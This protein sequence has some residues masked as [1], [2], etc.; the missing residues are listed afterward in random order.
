MHWR[1]GQLNIMDYRDI[2]DYSFERILKLVVSNHMMKM[3][4][5]AQNKHARFI[6]QKAAWHAQV[7]N[8]WFMEYSFRVLETFLMRQRNLEIGMNLSYCAVKPIH[9]WFTDL[10]TFRTAP[11]GNIEY[12]TGL[13][14]GILFG[15]EN[16]KFS[17]RL[18]CAFHMTYETIHPNWPMTKT[19]VM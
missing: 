17:R 16:W 7:M 9:L 5:G 10:H 13:H 6:V 12:E 14:Q 8:S 3:V 1:T 2:L 19:L 15:T 4:C 11:T 18:F